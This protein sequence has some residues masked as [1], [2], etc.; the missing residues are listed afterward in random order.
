MSTIGEKIYFLRKKTGI[1][2]EGLG[3][4]LNVT[5]QAVSKW[6]NGAMQ[7]T[8]E[9]VKM[10]CK[11]FKVNFDYF[12]NDEIAVDEND[13][14]YIVDK[15]SSEDST[16][17]VTNSAEHKRKHIFLIIIS[18][19]ALSVLTV[20]CIIFGSIFL[21]LNLENNKGFEAVRTADYNVLGIIFFVLAIIFVVALVVLLVYS[22]LKK[23]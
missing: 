11:F 19:I 7:P 14:T 12:T 15:S 22:K 6:E 9:N 10:M 23:K 18:V 17:A 16:L 21:Y 8:T 4:E 2:Q 3:F 20:I 5:R 1:S 13:T